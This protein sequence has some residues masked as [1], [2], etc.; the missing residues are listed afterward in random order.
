MAGNGTWISLCDGSVKAVEALHVGDAVVNRLGE[1]T[2]VTRLAFRTRPLL[3]MPA[4]HLGPGVPF[5]PLLLAPSQGV[6]LAGSKPAYQT[7]VCEAVPASAL[8]LESAAPGPCVE[9]G[10]ADGQGVLGC[11]V[12]LAP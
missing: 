11:G 12:P 8:G 6:L 7:E 4:N 9:V 2:V 1:G 10:T 3:R 5:Q